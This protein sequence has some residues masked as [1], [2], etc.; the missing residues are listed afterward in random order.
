[1]TERTTR[2]TNKERDYY[3]RFLNQREKNWKLQVDEMEK[4]E[5]DQLAEQIAAAYDPVDV[6]C[7][8]LVEEWTR[9]VAATSAPFLKGIGERLAA[10]GI[11]ERLRPRATAGVSWIPRGE[12]VSAERRTELFRE[13]SARIVANKAARL[14]AIDDLLLSLRAAALTGALQSDEAQRLLEQTPAFA[15]VALPIAIPL[16]RTAADQAAARAA[17]AGADLQRRLFFGG[18]RP[19]QITHAA[20]EAETNAE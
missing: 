20:G 1:M 18:Y 5:R 13:G 8:E 19:L 12:N 7:A 4:A 15:E 16:L 14:R 10:A 11:P 9:A 17:S 6:G 2:M 3:L